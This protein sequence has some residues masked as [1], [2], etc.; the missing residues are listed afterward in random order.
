MLKRTAQKVQLNPELVQVRGVIYS[1]K[2][3]RLLRS[4]LLIAFVGT[5]SPSRNTVWKTPKKSMFCSNRTVDFFDWP[6]SVKI[7]GV[8][9]WCCAFTAV[10]HANDF[11]PISLS[12]KCME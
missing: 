9:G 5:G 11:I 10:L 7:F 2:A 1:Q 8:A 3:L 4:L 12:A 6:F